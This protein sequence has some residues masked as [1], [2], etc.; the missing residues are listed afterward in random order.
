MIE[1]DGRV[2]TFH[3]TG[4]EADQVFL[5]GD[6]NGWNER[7]HPMVKVGDRHWVLMLDLPP[8]EYEFKYLVDGVWYNDPEAHKY[9][10]N[11]WG[12]E[13]SVVIVP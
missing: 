4:V 8:G 2:V 3:L 12:S 13:N 1:W 5:V 11:P 9:L 6:F 7:S 10:L